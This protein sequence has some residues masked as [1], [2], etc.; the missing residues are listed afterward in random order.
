MEDSHSVEGG[1]YHLHENSDIMRKQNMQDMPTC[2]SST[3]DVGLCAHGSQENEDRPS[4][5]E[6]SVPVE[7]IRN[8]DFNDV[9]LEQLID[10]YVTVS[11]SDSETDKSEKEDSDT[12]VGNNL[13]SDLAGWA[14]THGI[15]DTA[16][17]S[18]LAILR[19]YNN[20]NIIHVITN[21]G[22]S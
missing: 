17:K 7:D 16:L 15:C 4:I 12:E 20:N 8:N 14:T 11:S 21:C 10:G 13:K 9:L 2:S 3:E 6:S 19:P 1:L 5:S 22:M 18:L